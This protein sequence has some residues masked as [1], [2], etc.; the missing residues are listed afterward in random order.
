VLRLKVLRPAAQC[1]ER[2]AGQA[3]CSDARAGARLRQRAVVHPF[4]AAAGPAAAPKVRGSAAV[5][6]AVPLQAA[7]P[8]SVAAAEQEPAAVAVAAPLQAVA[9]VWVAA[10]KQEPGVEAEVSDAAARQ[11]AGVAAAVAL[12][13]AVVP[14][15]VEAAAS[16]AK[17]RR[18]AGVAAAEVV[19]L[20]A[21]AVPLQAAA[22]ARAVVAVR[23]PVG[24]AALGGEPVRQPAEVAA[25]GVPAEVARLA[26]VAVR[27]SFL[28]P[29]PFPVPSAPG[30]VVP[31][32][33]VPRPV[34]PRLVVPRPAGCSAHA[35]QSLRIA[36]RSEW[37][38]QAA[39]DEIWSW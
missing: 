18:P 5:A 26:S 17:A 15:P 39:R 11:P 1:P 4:P 24:V 35:R 13:A 32:L 12:D 37:S 28:V 6:A 23:R 21:A 25:R 36:S 29:F 8:V 2:A 22:E 14:R 34:V 10:A 30:L 20:D 7:A 16:D 31:R 27:P 3:E 19:A 33:V 38:R 9:P